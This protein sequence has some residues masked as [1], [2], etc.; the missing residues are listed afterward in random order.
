MVAE[1][2]KSAQCDA[3][4]TNQRTSPAST[5]LRGARLR[6]ALLVRLTPR[7]I[8]E[9][10]QLDAQGEADAGEGGDQ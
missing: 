8:N 4:P 2:A 3:G 5:I 1:A 9:A 7:S 10:A 6:A